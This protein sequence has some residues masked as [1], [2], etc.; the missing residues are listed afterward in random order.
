MV[1]LVAY[2]RNHPGKVSHGSSGAGSF[3]HVTME[4]FK[5]AADLDV[6]HVPYRGNSQADT[7]LVAGH[8]SL[9]FTSLA[10]SAPLL[11]VNKLKAFAVTSR[12]RLPFAGNVPAMTESGQADLRD[13]E[14]IYWV[15]VMAPSGTPAPVVKKLNDEINGWLQTA[16][17]KE[18]L[19][20]RKIDASRPMGP[21]E[22]SR[23]ISGEKTR[24]AKVLRDAKIEPQESS[25]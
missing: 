6:V 7:D 12:A 18:K 15:G 2:L 17:F 24:W 23:L 21:D 25:N 3:A 11:A 1:E 5:N 22:M 8:V 20:T 14:V 16:E 9:M 19:A 10:E 13:F 4:V